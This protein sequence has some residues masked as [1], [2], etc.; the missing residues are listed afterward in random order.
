MHYATKVFT[1]LWRKISHWNLPSLPSKQFSTN[2]LAENVVNW[3]L[4]FWDRVKLVIKIK[5]GRDSAKFFFAD[6]I[7]FKLLE[8]KLKKKSEARIMEDSTDACLIAVFWY[9]AAIANTAYKCF[10][11]GLAS[12]PT[13]LTI[14]EQGMLFG[15]AGFFSITGQ[16][17][18]CLGF[19]CL[20]YRY[21]RMYDTVSGWV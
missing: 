7:I 10:C 16:V 17:V 19:V 6:I 9:I 2:T 1:E 15:E 21:K 5:R 14:G 12:K 8:V 11:L 20:A 3:P 13:E 4:L 18:G